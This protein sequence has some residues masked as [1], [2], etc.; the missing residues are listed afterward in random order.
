M[1]TVILAPLFFSF[2]WPSRAHGQTNI[3]DEI[4]FIDQDGKIQVL[5]INQ[6][7]PV[8]IDWA[9]SEDGFFDFAVGDF[10]SDGDFEVAGIKGAGE[11]GRLVVYDPVVSP[12]S[13]FPTDRSPNRV[14]WKLLY[15]RNIGFTPLIIGAGNLDESTPEDEILLG[16]DVGGGQS[17][18]LVLKIED[19]NIIQGTGAIEFVPDGGTE[20]RLRF[21]RSWDSVSIGQLDGTGP[22]EIVLTDSTII[23][24]QLQSRIAFYRVADLSAAQP[25]FKRSNSFASWRATRIGEINGSG[26]PETIAIRKVNNGATIPTVFFFEYDLAQQTIRDND[27]GCPDEPHDPRTC[28]DDVDSLFLLPRPSRVFLADMTGSGDNEAFFLRSVSP[29]DNDAR[30]FL[31]NRGDDNNQIVGLN[32]A[33]DPQTLHPL[34]ALDFII[35]NDNLWQQG[36]G[37]DFDGDGQDE[38]AIGRPNRIRIYKELNNSN[39][40]DIFREDS[41]NS[42]NLQMKAANLDS[43][44]FS[45][46]I[47]IFVD[48]KE[49]PEAIHTGDKSSFLLHVRSFDQSVIARLEAPALPPWIEIPELPKTGQTPFTVTAMIDASDLLPG[50]YALD[51]TVSSA[52]RFVTNSPLLE[53]IA[54]NILPAKIELDPAYVS[55]VEHPCDLASFSGRPDVSTTVRLDGT[56]GVPFAADIVE[57]AA[58]TPVTGIEWVSIESTSQSLPADVV[59]T[60]H[61]MKF[62]PDSPARRVKVRIVVDPEAGAAATTMFIPVAVLCAQWQVFSPVVYP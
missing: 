60:I 31:I 3:D 8:L 61:P 16:Y 4:L 48:A 21:D 6:A 9:S 24:D 20:S 5:D 18:L 26:Q 29:P 51:L 43:N 37:G 36:T 46:D 50:D 12:N 49:L 23:P 22:D 55:Y 15:E 35:D 13:S 42:A 40:L 19:V 62:P 39:R 30:F 56:G 41:V 10:N 38:I 44:Q 32:T 28:P 14:P 1:C 11:T 25:F 27:D 54:L 59:I 17:E 45:T 52:D 47:E 57:E 58:L 53:K 33:I 2:F 34:N 7:S